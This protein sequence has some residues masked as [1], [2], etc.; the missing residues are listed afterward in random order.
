[1]GSGL[2]ERRYQAVLRFIGEC[3]GSKSFTVQELYR[4]LKY[5][6]GEDSTLKEL[7]K[8][9]VLRV[10]RLLQRLSKIGYLTEIKG[11]GRNSNVYKLLFINGQDETVKK[12]FIDSGKGSLIK[13]DSSDFDGERADMQL[14]VSFSIAMKNLRRREA[15][16]IKEL[17]EVRSLIKQC[18]SKILTL[19]KSEAIK[20][21]EDLD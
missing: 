4:Q 3:F 19:L 7:S 9:Q 16:L 6:S 14:L 18:E 2:R 10:R 15:F 13:L 8:S 12:E 1:M 20:L 21:P 5:Y 11:A 17:S